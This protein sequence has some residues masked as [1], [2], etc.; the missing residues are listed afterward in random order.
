MQ[1]EGKIRLGISIGDLNGIGCEVV[2]KT[3]E[4]A[5]MLDFCTPVIFASNKT[6]SFQKK[7]LGLDINYHGVSDASKAVDGK[8]NVVNVW[9]EVPKI[10][11]GEATP[12]AGKFAIASLRAA[13][14]A[15]K[16]DSI[17]V[18]VTAPINKNNIQAD[19]FKFPGHT[20]FL[21][22][23]LEGESLMFMVTDDLKVGLLTDHL[24]VKDVSAAINPILIR[25]KVRTIEKSLQMDFGIRA[26]KIALLG[27]NPHSGDNG[28]IGKEDDE[29]LKPVI[30]EM[31]DAGHLVFGPYSADSFFGSDAYKSFDAILAAYHDQGLIPFK[32]LSFGKGVN[33]TA[34]LSKVRTSPDHGTAYEIAGKGEADPSSFK[35]AVFTALHIFKNRKEYQEL[36]ANPLQK[37]RIRR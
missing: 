14:E 1:E 9:K 7:E 36:T 33:Y 8:I 32:T 10:K 18:L 37:Q 21:A 13:V 3:F 16:N 22:Q 28:V 19:D 20:D 34:G 29:V 24:A 4:D 23:E 31:S 15:L 2:L 5:R 30:K 25:D 35:E 17:D 6:I 11:F 12:E 26:P 27:I